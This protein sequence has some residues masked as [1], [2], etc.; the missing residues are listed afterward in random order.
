MSL[1]TILIY[2]YYI[3]NKPRKNITATAHNCKKF[4]L[5]YFADIVIISSLDISELFSYERK[6]T[7]TI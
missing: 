2:L 4:L 3:A 6:N 7:S 5:K 1:I